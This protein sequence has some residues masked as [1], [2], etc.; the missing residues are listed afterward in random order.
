[1]KKNLHFKKLIIVVFLAGMS[2]AGWS[3][4]LYE[5]FNYTTPAYI[6][7]NGNTGTTSN[8]WT[9]HRLQPVI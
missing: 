9:T 7:G 5:D 8:N 6:G 2:L 4:V 1:M 3:Q